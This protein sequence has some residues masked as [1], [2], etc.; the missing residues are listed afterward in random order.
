MC[1]GSPV[2]GGQVILSSPN[3]P[4][5]RCMGFLTD[6]KLAAEAALYGN[7]GG[8][9]QVVWHNGVLALTAVGV[10]VDL[11]TNLTQRGRT[12]AYLAYDGQKRRM[13]VLEDREGSQCDRLRGSRAEATDF[14]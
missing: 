6:E 14:A 4:C 8:R 2:I 12:Y 13:L 3:G 11:V 10:A 9:R 5:I 7:A 1:T